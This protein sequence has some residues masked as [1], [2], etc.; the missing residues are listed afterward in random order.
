MPFCSYIFLLTH[1]LIPSVSIGLLCIVCIDSMKMIMI[2]VPLSRSSVIIKKS[3][4]RPFVYCVA[5]WVFVESINEEG[6]R[7]N[8]YSN[9]CSTVFILDICIMAWRK[10]VRNYLGSWEIFI[11]EVTL[12]C[13][14]I[15]VVPVTW[16]YYIQHI[17]VFLSLYCILYALPE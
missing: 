6:A 15:S 17:Y 14:A 13:H 12:N 9:N 3:L 7:G 8:A 11:E 2:W 16:V 1:W 4:Q 5:H 10:K